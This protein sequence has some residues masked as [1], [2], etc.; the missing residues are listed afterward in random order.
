MEIKA[1][2]ISALIKAQIKEYDHKV[3][4]KDVGTVITVGDGIALVYGLDQAMLGELLVFPDDVYGMV[5]NLEVN[6][7]RDKTLNKRKR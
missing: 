3:E 7:K 6:K 1:D 5:L 4:S 2:E